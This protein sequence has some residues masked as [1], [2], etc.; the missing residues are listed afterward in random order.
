MLLHADGKHSVRAAVVDNTNGAYS[1]AFRLELQGEWL[2]TPHVNGA[3][4]V[5]AAIKV[6]KH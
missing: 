6:C 3:D 2:L 5:A 1:L 4:I